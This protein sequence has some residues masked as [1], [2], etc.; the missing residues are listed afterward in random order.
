MHFR[1]VLRVPA[2][3][4]LQAGLMCGTGFAATGTASLAVS[5]TVEAGCEVSYAAAGAGDT[6][7]RPDPWNSPVSV[8]CTLPV[9]HQVVFERSP[10]SD[11]GERGP[12]IWSH[13]GLPRNLQQIYNREPAQGG[14]A[15][16]Q[17]DALGEKPEPALSEFVTRSLPASLLEAAHCAA[18][19]PDAKT[20][21][22]TV[23]Y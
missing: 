22:V 1:S 20:V 18:D 8:H 9:S 4:L 19:D 14:D 7:S 6:Q 13:S 5:V 15:K 16:E 11:S 3:V 21:T 10:G 12:G 23:I 17:G 2:M